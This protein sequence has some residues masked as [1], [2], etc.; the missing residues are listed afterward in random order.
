MKY[1]CIDSFCGAGGLA[2][3]LIRAGFDIVLSFDNDPNCI[4]TMQRN[5]D[6]FHHKAECMGIEDILAGNILKNTGIKRG[7][8]F[9]LAGGPPCQGFSIQ[10]IGKDTDKRNKLVTAYGKLLEILLPKYFL[11]ENVPGIT[12]KRGTHFLSQII[13]KAEKLGYCVHEKILNAQNYGVPQRRKRMILV[14][15]RLDMGAPNFIYPQ[16]SDEIVTVRETID[17]L[18]SP[19]DDGSTHPDYSLHRKDRLSAINQ[20]RIKALKPGEGRDALPEELLANCHRISSAKIGHPNVYGRMPWDDV[21][22]TITAR[23]D[24]FTRGMFGHPEQTRSISLREG[25]LLQTFPLNFDFLGTKVSIAKQIGNAVPVNF[26]YAIA[27]QI[28]KCYLAKTEN[29]K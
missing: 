4:A 19:P 14:G 27:N 28:V 16:P 22:P 25:A 17:F 11:M 6:Y 24:S 5:S 9:L 15:E 10:R 1:T 20:A 13:A 2:L 12:G 23:F 18:P 7:E 29:Q 21:A 8:L 3:G 26:A